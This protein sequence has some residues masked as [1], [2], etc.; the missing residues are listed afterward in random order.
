[1]NESII[2]IM[3]DL[4]ATSALSTVILKK[5]D[6][7]KKIIVT[8]SDGGFPYKIADVSAVLSAK[9]PDGTILYN[10]C[11]IEDNKIVY[12]V[13]LQTTTAVGKM[14]CEVRLYG[15]DNAVLTSA[16]FQILVEDVVYDDE[17]PES[18][19]EFTALTK[20]MSELVRI[21]KEGEEIYMLKGATEKTLQEIRDLH[22]ASMLTDATGSLDAA[23]ISGDVD[24]IDLTARKAFA[25]AADL[26]G[27]VSVFQKW[28]NG[29]WGKTVGTDNAARQELLQR[30]FGTVLD[31]DRVHGV[32]MPLFST[33]EAATSELTDDSVGL[34]AA[35]STEATAGQD[36]F[37][38][39]PQFFCIE[40]AADK[41]ADGSHEIFAVEYID[42]ISVV[43]SGEHLCWVLQ[44]NTYT[45][46][47]NEG[48]YK[49]FKTRC[50]P[51]TGYERWPQGKDKLN[52][53]YEYMANPK[54]AAGKGADGKPTC[55]TG[56]EPY[57]Y[58]SY[59]AGI[60]AWRSKGAQYAG[61]S[62]N[63]PKFQLA[64]IWLKYGKKGNSGT[65][66]GCTSYNYQYTAAV[67]E[68]G[69]E[70]I[71]LTTAQAAN[72][73]EGS[74]TIVGNKGTGTSTD[75]GVASMYSICK[76]KRI[77]S[78][79]EVTISGT[80]YAAVNI[81]NGGVTFDTV[82]GETYLSTMPY[83]SGWNDTVQGFDGSRYSATSGKEP[84]LIQKTEFQTGAYLILAD[85]LWQWGTDSDGNF[86]FDCYVCHDQSKVTTN[87]TISSDYT[88]CDD[89]TLTFPSGTTDKWMYIEDTATSKDSAVLWPA[90]VSTKAGSGTGVK[91]G[92]YVAPR[93]SG[94]RAPWLFGGLSFGGVAG[95]AARA[96]Y[97]GPGNSTWSGGVGA[98]GLAG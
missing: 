34:T 51:A 30:W 1:M 74:N 10:A 76:C 79:E 21:S 81:D 82:A 35:P 69:V 68:T 64:M 33:S 78:I 26:K 40:V 67:S 8:L 60:Q 22:K 29:N 97:F 75:R 59:N 47:W 83:Y 41:N 19:S 23:I 7:S 90:A 44:K 12:D 31:D 28:W 61:A 56:L 57:L 85:E 73:F 48:G 36:D 4:Q 46:E 71:I 13:T 66:E 32:K 80:T 58:T 24:V 54:Y 43:R 38:K 37:A 77:K 98:P 91:A 53:E 63:L 96:S 17:L 6:T 95:L 15:A 65:I 3:L 86:T 93:T 18:S 14:M 25:D 42:D 45:R 49:Y 87:G 50:H 11:S 89:L 20:M 70:R 88:K 55:G 39:L 9:K 84:G 94:V 52:R 72:L 5:G 92:M 16:R 2:H 62:G 27:A